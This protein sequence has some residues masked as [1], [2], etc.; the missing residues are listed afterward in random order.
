MRPD[1]ACVRVHRRAGLALGLVQRADGGIMRGKAFAHYDGAA[2]LV[3]VPR[4]TLGRGH[5]AIGMHAAHQR[6]M[7]IARAHTAG[8]PQH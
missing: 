3:P 1:Y 5:V 7:P 4:R 2:L 8:E 6:T